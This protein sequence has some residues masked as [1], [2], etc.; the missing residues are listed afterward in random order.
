[1]IFTVVWKKTA[2]DALA[3]LW[4]RHPGRTGSFYQRG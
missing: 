3:D 1:M 4:V 2:E